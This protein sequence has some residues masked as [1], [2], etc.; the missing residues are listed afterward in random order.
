MRFFFSWKVV[1]AIFVEILHKDMTKSNQGKD[2]AHGSRIPAWAIAI[3]AISIILPVASW[4]IQMADYDFG[5]GNQ[6]FILIF[7][8]PIYIIL[9]GFLAYKCFPIRKEITYIL[10]ALMWLSSAAIYLLK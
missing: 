6:Y 3:V 5:S 10:L 9:C 2:D 8:F 7:L 1:N 4:L